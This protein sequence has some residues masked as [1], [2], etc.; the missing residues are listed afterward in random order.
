MKIIVDADGCPKGVLKSCLELG[1]QYGL[2]VYTVA[3]IHHQI[4]S[5]HHITVDGASQQADLKIANMT[6]AADVVITQDWGL[7][8]LILGKK[9]FCLHPSGRQYQSETIEFLLEEREAKARFRR[10]GNRT[11]GPKKRREEEDVHFACALKRLLTEQVTLQN[12]CP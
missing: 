9:A 5:E 10:G 6:R 7:A 3:N 12:Q 11:K 2:I 1:K 8:A 4:Q